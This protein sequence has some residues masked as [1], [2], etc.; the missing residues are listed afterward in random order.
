MVCLFVNC[1]V[2]E[3]YSADAGS[4]IEIYGK[5]AYT[6]SSISELLLKLC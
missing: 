1:V 2:V 4:L 3:A 6:N 5:E